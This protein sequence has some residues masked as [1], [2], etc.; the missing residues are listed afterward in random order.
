[1]KYDGDPFA[2]PSDPLASIEA[3]F[4]HPTTA[5]LIRIF[6]LQ[7][8]LKDARQGRDFK[9]RHVHVVGAGVMGGDIAAMCAM[10]G[11]TV[12]LQDT[13]P[14]RLAPAV[15]RSAELFKQRLRDPRR[16]RDALRPPDPRRERRGR[17]P[18]RRDH[19]GDLREPRSEAIAVF[20]TW[21]R[22]QN[23]ERSSPATP[24]A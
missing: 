24:P 23:P 14:E 16:V 20:T 17:A 7:E 21:K 11:L 2:V 4:A 5:N 8:R 22:L 15:K 12:T 6:F 13:S 1:M 3:L 10:R 18:G 9:A 19:R